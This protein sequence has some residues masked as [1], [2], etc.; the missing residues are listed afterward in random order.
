V[1]LKIG[2]SRATIVENYKTEKAHGKDENQSWAIA[3]ET[4][5]RAGGHYPRKKKKHWD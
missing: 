5:R 4:A 1:P 2:K 3:Y